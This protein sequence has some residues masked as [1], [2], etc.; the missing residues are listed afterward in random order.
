MVPLKSQLCVQPQ[1]LL[2]GAGATKKA[3][4]AAEGKG[5]AWE[6]SKSF[7]SWESAGVVPGVPLGTLL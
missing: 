6:D 5:G 7:I 2:S 1:G 3:E 4:N